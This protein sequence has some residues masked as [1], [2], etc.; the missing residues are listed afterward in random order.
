MENFELSQI[1]STGKKES[2]FDECKSL[3]RDYC[4]DVDQDF[5][6]HVYA[7]IYDMFHGQYPGFG[8]SITKYHDFYHTCASTLAAIRLFHGLI[9]DGRQISSTTIE[10]GV[11]SALFH[12]V[13]WLS[14][15]DGRM[16]SRAPSF[17]NHEER[18]ISFTRHYLQQ[19]GFSAAYCND[20]T[21]IIRCTNLEV[22][23][24]TLDFRNESTKLGGCVV[25]SA[26]LL[27]QMA[28]RCYLERLPFLF[29]E[30][31]FSTLLQYDTPAELLQRTAE[32]YSKTVME[33][34]EKTF[35]NV[36]SSMRSHFRTRWGLDRDLYSDNIIKNLQYLKRV[37]VECEEEFQCVE[38]RL[39]RNISS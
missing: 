29:R 6:E 25:G 21:N 23:P 28:D 34:L 10:Q 14:C 13:G 36:Y 33:R 27:A 35:C 16:G 19:K 8:V 2:S 39:R 12:D 24:D 30:Q 26:D 5:L 15:E 20:C 22:Y 9:I 37:I 17:D 18:S 3:I 32:F 1:F 31:G 38:K 7:D 4:T 11:V